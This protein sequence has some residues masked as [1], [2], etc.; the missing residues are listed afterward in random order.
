MA[1]ETQLS[2]L[3]AS[4]GGQQETAISLLTRILG[5][6]VDNPKE[7]KFR[8]LNPNSEKLKNDLLR[9]EGALE[10]LSSLGFQPTADGHLELPLGAAAPEA[11]L[12]TLKRGGYTACS[13]NLHV[14]AEERAALQSLDTETLQILERILD[15]IRRYPSSEKYRCINLAKASGHKVL[16]ALPLLHAAGF[17]RTSED[18]LQLQ[19][20]QVDLLER[21]WAM[22][23]W[24]GRG[25]ETIKELPSPKTL[26][27]RA[28]GALLGAAVGDALGAPLSGQD[29]MAVTAQEV[30][31]ALEMCGGGR[32]G[33]APGQ[34]SGNTELQL[35]TLAALAEAES[36]FP[37]EDVALRYGKW[38]K[39]LP[40]KGDKACIQVFA[41]PM[42]AE[43]MAE[44]AREVNQKSMSCGAMIRCPALAVAAP[45]EK[46]AQLANEDVRLSHPS[47]VMARACATYTMALALLVE[48]KGEDVAQWLKR[49]LDRIKSGQSDLAKKPQPK[50]AKEETWAPPG[51][52]LVAC[53][54]V[55]RWLK[56][57]RGAELL[58][59]SDMEATSLLSHEVG[60]VEIPFCHAFRHL[61]LGTS[62]EE[63]MRAILAGGGDSSS[64]A[65]ITGALLGAAL[66]VE[67]IPERWLRAVLACDQS[68][69][70]SRPTEF[71]PKEIPGLCKR[72]LAKS[73]R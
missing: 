61:H 10:L 3:C 38:G 42:T 71:H 30:G 66:G 12:A 13:A 44:R 24:A 47:R 26:G 50:E 31:K 11:A 29:P 32:W 65:S 48:E 56:R 58:P 59:F 34:V 57:A 2:R 73:K 28:L 22:V 67:G 6:L 9:H 72:I 33:V 52:E 51:E 46:A 69:G 60:T 64:T 1:I 4:A 7:A 53:E 45:P 49:S 54:E 27:S 5:N 68:H 16:P 20:P 37:L 23:W 36:A 62:F 43:S 35:C 40:F 14:K 15:N 18:L 21:A 17:Q 25:H 39:S 63:A 19:R 41:R 70:Q 55:L 8:R